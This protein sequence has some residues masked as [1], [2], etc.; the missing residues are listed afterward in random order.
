MN[1]PTQK[2]CAICGYKFKSFLEQNNGWPI[3]DK[4]VCYECD[5][6]FVLPARIAQLYEKEKKGAK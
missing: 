1:E 4:S 3:T 2:Q 6:K 5:M